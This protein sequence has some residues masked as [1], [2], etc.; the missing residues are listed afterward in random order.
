MLASPTGMLAWRCDDATIA[1]NLGDRK[2]EVTAS[3]SIAVSTN[4]ERQGERT[5][6]TLMLSPMEAAIVL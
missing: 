2:T 6:G 4:R 5:T 1:I 3:G